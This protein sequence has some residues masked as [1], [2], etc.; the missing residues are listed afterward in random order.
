MYEDHGRQ[1]RGVR[2]RDL[3]LLRSGHTSL[4]GGCDICHRVLHSLWGASDLWVAL[5][6]VES[7]DEPRPADNGG[8]VSETSRTCGYLHASSGTVG[9]WMLWKRPR[10]RL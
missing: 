10:S 9:R 1:A 4:L 7:F 3:A 6:C 5:G 2:P 8:K